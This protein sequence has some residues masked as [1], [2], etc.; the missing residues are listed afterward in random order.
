MQFEQ[1]NLSKHAEGAILLRLPSE[2]AA[3][4][5][6]GSDRSDD[7]D[8]KGRQVF[9]NLTHDA[10]MMYYNTL[11][12]NTTTHEANGS[13]DSVGESIE[14]YQFVFFGILGHVLTVFGLLGNTMSIVVLCNRRMRSST[15]Y[16]LISLAVYDN[17]ILLSMFFFFNLPALAERIEALAVYKNNYMHALP[18]GYPLSLTA[19]MGSIY[20]CVAFT[21]ERFIAVCRPLHAANTCTKS[22]ARKAILLIFLWSV[23]YNVPRCFHYSAERHVDN[24]TGEAV[25]RLHETELGKT[26]TFQH[27]YIIYFQLF[28]MFLL[29]FLVILV[30]NAALM[31]AINRSRNTRQRMST[32]ATREHNLTVMLVAVILAFLVCQFPT[33]VDNILVAI[34]GFEMHGSIF[35]FMVFY[36]ICTFMVTI[37]ASLNFVLYCLFG[38]K[39][40][41]VLLHILGLRAAKKECHY[42]STIYQS[43]TNGTRTT[44]CDMKVSLV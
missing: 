19:Q 10:N 21:V 6:Q 29:P 12:N 31:R 37:N 7:I 23:V 18:V 38:K 2:P 20:T 1:G 40:R 16:Y 9:L 4:A 15:S 8:E 42:R 28:F 43:R 22:R 17:L 44:N 41:L 32:S 27:V 33:I 36:T 30:L 13:E 3:M 24:A 34:V 14:A 39:F 25:A 35:A 26:E 11:L 5:H